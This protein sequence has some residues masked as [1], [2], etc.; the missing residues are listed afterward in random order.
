[1][2]QKRYKSLSINVRIVKST[3]TV[4]SV[5]TGTVM[6]HMLRSGPF[7]QCYTCT[8]SMSVAL[9]VTTNTIID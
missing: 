3:V 2:C 1:M 9:F 5:P 6:L 8:Q 4:K 7:D